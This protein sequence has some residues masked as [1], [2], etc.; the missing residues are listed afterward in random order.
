MSAPTVTD[1]A[2]RFAAALDAN[3]W[4]AALGLLAPRC[5]Y[6]CRG[7][8]SEGGD[9]IV[10]SYREIGEW[11]AATFA[12]VRYA[13]EVVSADPPHVLLEFR[14]HMRHGDH[15]LD[16][17]CRQRLTVDADGKIVAIAH[18]DLPGERDKADRFNAACGVKR[19]GADG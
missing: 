3:D 5:R 2:Q 10:A 9:A 14:D 8:T 18:I 12:D 13:S 16:F 4:D 1:V 11:V 17:R 7:T 6:D 15:V 19:P